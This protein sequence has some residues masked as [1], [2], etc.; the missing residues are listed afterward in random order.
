MTAHAHGDI[1][2]EDAQTWFRAAQSAFKIAPGGEG[3][4]GVG[5]VPAR[6]RLLPVGHTVVAA[7][8]LNPDDVNSALLTFV[9]TDVA[10]PATA[11][12]MLVLRALL[13]EPCFSELRYDPTHTFAYFAC[14]VCEQWRGGFI[15]NATY[16][17]AHARASLYGITMSSR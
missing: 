4:S 13:A 10:T 7:A 6:A 5:E 16:R 2:P 1:A 14:P 12:R 11:A 9:Q 8:G 17:P 15:A 3:G